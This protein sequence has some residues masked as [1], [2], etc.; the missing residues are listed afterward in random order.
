MAGVLCCPR[1]WFIWHHR[2][3][4]RGPHRRLGRLPVRAGCACPAGC[5]RA[6]RTSGSVRATAAGIR[7]AGMK[8][9]RGAKRP[10]HTASAQG[11]GGEADG[12]VRLHPDAY[13]LE[14]AHRFEWLDGVG[15]GSGRSEA[16]TRGGSVRRDGQLPGVRSVLDGSGS[17]V[18][19]RQRTALPGA[20][21]G[22]GTSGALSGA[23]C[24]TGHPAVMGPLRAP[25]PHF[26]SGGRM[27]RKDWR[28]GAGGLG[29][30]V[31]DVGRGVEHR[32]IA[33]LPVPATPT[34]GG[35]PFIHRAG[36]KNR[37][38]VPAEVRR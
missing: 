25:G 36:A 31:A 4:G 3:P 7:A 37:R 23:R 1:S 35:D 5:A 6:S 12:V 20:A 38:A 16:R 21:H 15:C 18:P 13:G 28:P 34:T 33:R 30:A 26:L 29:E 22:P 11:G 14:L 10:G 8:P 32:L 9:R 19:S 27:V 17:A 24:E 2:P